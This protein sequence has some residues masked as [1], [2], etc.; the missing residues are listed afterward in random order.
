MFSKLKTILTFL[1][2]VKS[3]VLIAQDP[4]YTQF[5]SAPLT[6]N[7]AYT[8]VFSGNLRM[9]TIYRSQWS[10]MASPFTS[11]VAS[12]D[13][14][15]F[16]DGVYHQN[17]F[18]M[19]IMMQS[20]KTLKGALTSSNLTATA[21]YHIPL[22]MEGDQSIG[23]GL[24]ATYGKRNFNFN[25]LSSA[26]Q[27]TSG[28]FD[29]TL[30]SGEVAFENMKP[31]LS[32]GAGVLYC[33]TNE[34]EGSFFEIGAA[35]FHV[36][37]PLETILYEGTSVIPMRVSAH[38]FLQRYV[39]DDLLIDLRLMY[40]LQTGADYLMGGFALKKLL[41]SDPEGSLLGLGCWYRT[42]DAIAP[43]IFAEFKSMRVGFSYD[44]QLNGIRK[45]AAPA[46]SM[47]FSLQYRLK[48]K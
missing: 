41:E 4:H 7:P 16:N 19:G 11:M 24:S 1:L 17:P 40:Q 12:V 9:G 29:L 22:N 42:G 13:G 39:S 18:N 14:K 15:L 37:R 44:I 33:N 34:E 31:Y 36:N 25:N 28:G 30:P 47:E 8:G 46:S 43:N 3:L 32:V 5:Y 2:V 10:S 48:S 35:A 6:I 20:D 38:T 21:A 26:S 27:F 45:T 23:L